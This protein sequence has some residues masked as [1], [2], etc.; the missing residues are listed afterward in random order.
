MPLK[1]LLKNPLATLLD[2]RE[3]E[4]L[5]DEKSIPGAVSIPMKEIPFRLEEIRELSSPLIIF[6]RSGNRSRSVVGY[7]KSQG[8]TNL[9][10]GGSFKRIIELLKP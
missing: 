5:K 6:C 2:V 4:E 1:E 10:D 9:Y 8:F 7:L 3:E